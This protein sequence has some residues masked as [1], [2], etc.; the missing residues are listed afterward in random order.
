MIRTG[1]FLFRGQVESKM[2]AIKLKKDESL[3]M[4]EAS[5]ISLVRAERNQAT[6][7]V[8]CENDIDLVHRDGSVK[9]TWTKRPL[10]V[11]INQS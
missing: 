3:K 11:E 9:K 10:D 2:P 7:F 5:T 4:K 1:R 8:T 6:I